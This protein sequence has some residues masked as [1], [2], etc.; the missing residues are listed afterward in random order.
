MR[1]PSGLNRVG[2]SDA[3]PPGPRFSRVLGV[4][5]LI[6][7]LLSAVGGSILY[8]LGVVAGSALA[9]T[10]AAFLIAGLAFVLAAAVYSEGNSLH[11]ERG[12]ASMF[13]RYALDEFWSFVAG[14]AILLDY[15]IVM[16]LAVF[17]ATHYLTAFFPA[18]GE[19]PGEALVALAIVGFVAW[20]NIRGMSAL[21]LN[22]L[23]RAGVANF[24]LL[25]VIVI[26]GL[27]TLGDPLMVLRSVEFGGWPGAEDLIFA[28]VIAAAA[29]TGI[30]SASG[31][32]GELR[33]GRG[34]LRRVVLLTLLI[35]PATLVGVSIVGLMA[36]PVVDGNTLLA[37]RW[38]D[39]PLLGVASAFE[40]AGLRAALTAGVGA[41]GVIVL[42]LAANGNMLGLSRLGYSLA[43]NRQ[44]PSDLGRLHPERATPFVLI[45]IAA[46]IVFG[47]TLSS[48]I[49]FLAGLFAFG[50]TLAFTIAQ[51]SVVVLRFR[52]P[53]R[54]RPFRIRP[55]IDVGRGSIPIPAL[56][57]AVAGLA[58]W[59][60]VVVY[61]E[62]A[63]LAGSAWLLGGVLM[64]VI[65]RT[66]QGK[67]LRKRFVIP[68]QSLR[69]DSDLAYG[70]IL[71]PVF[72]RELDDDIVGT[73]GRLAAEE[74]ED[75]E[76]IIDAIYVIEIPMSL[77][78]DAR[79]PDER[80]RVARRA[81]TRAKEVGEE[82][83]GVLVETA[84]VRGRNAGQT[85]VFEARR[86]GVEV[87]VLAAE[88]PTRTRGGSLLGGSGAPR[89]RV[90][91]QVT[92]Y[93]ID[94]A[95][96]RVV[97]TAPPSGEDTIREGVA[98]D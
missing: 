58:A 64:Y 21:R 6:A 9:L 73:A 45:A 89:D 12:G 31:L 60:S 29:L 23:L 70:S 34:G 94:K 1:L 41:I 80:V 43:T 91:G 77:P 98:P 5:A 4:P 61:H 93:V 20:S 11:P 54:P 87:I 46:T 19:W 90:V 28:T 82:Y 25:I 92:Q 72:G 18:A 22:R 84:T 50:A 59:I 53:D 24:S 3:R 17:A 7:I 16:A 52:E 95:P 13:A 68:E 65:Y 79:I 30:E 56:L 44:I 40:P 33:V 39:A 55:S 2:G 42:V 63:R 96:C 71:V 78:I 48:D 26:L 15:L 85:I 81:L 51:I 10:P 66:A 74:A 14:W 76:V 62:G 75:D 69:D 37:T 38:V 88:D 32:A 27:L 47:L 67:S 57:G 35:V 36:F 83:E 49:D 97:L 8:G 86:R